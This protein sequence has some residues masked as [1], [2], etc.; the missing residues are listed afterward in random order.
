VWDTELRGFV[1]RVRASGRRWFAVEWMRE[2]RTRRLS[3]G[4]FGAVTVDQARERAKKILG[5]VA[6]PATRRWL[7]RCWTGCCTT[8]TSSTSRAGPIGCGTSKG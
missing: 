2:R 1:V 3:L 8:A 4:E 7:R 5:R 6:S